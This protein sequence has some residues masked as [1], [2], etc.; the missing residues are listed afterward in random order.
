MRILLH[1][2]G[3]KATGDELLE[4]EVHTLDCREIIDVYIDAVNSELVVSFAIKSH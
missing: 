1:K 3:R 4:Q 2:E